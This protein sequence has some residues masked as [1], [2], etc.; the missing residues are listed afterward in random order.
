[1]RFRRVAGHGA[2]PDT[3]GDAMSP[4]NPYPIGNIAT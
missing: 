4:G 3:D 2:L 1:M